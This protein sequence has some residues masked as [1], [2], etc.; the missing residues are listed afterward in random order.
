MPKLLY[1][2]RIDIQMLKIVIVVIKGVIQIIG[3][4]QCIG[5]NK[6]DRLEIRQ[7]VCVLI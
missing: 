1:T 5:N 7:Y 6:V 2:L 4:N 3:I